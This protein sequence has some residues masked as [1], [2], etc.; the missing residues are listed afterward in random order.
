MPMACF[1]P[2]GRRE[3]HKNRLLQ[4]LIF[5]YEA[6]KLN[7]LLWGNMYQVLWLP[8]G[9]AV[10]PL[11]TSSTQALTGPHHYTVPSPGPGGTAEHISHI[12]TNMNVLN[13]YGAKKKSTQN[14]QKPVGRYLDTETKPFVLEMAGKSGLWCHRV[15]AKC[16][17][18]GFD[19]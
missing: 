19:T 15:S 2:R 7:E 13:Y 3:E 9:W 6:G 11:C 8:T 10:G 17:S 5:G 12:S 4:E 18:G 14:T 1:C 16:L